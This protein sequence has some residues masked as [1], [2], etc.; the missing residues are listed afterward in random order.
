MN[1]YLEEWRRHRR[2]R[3][4]RDV[5]TKRY[6]W[7]IPSPAAISMLVRHSPIVEIGAGKGYWASLVAAAGGRILCFDKHPPKDQWHPVVRGGPDMASK[8]SD[9]TL[10][11]CWPPYWDNMAS[12]CLQAYRGQTL[13]YVGETEGGCNAT[14]DFFDQL[15]ADWVHTQGVAIPQ[16]EGIRDYLFV[17]TRK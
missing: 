16:W 5:L 17:F 11:L 15:Q 2:S 4:A 7:A 10:F 14:D 6:A 1:E 3:S 8:H 9:K 13:V 12:E